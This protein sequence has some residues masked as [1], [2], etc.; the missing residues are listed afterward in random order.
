MP[1]KQHALDPKKY[2]FIDTSFNLLM[3]R[4]IYQILLISSNYDAFMLEEDGRIDETIFMEYFSLSLRYPPQ[5]IKVTSEEEAFEV[6]EDK[7]IELVISMLSIDQTDTF[8]LAIRIKN[9]FPKIPIVV[10]TPFSREVNIKL[11]EKNLSAID[12]VF[13]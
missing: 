12:Y 6:L 7:R 10:L 5:F 11:R 8:D 9:K 4:R 13:S 2:Y 3:K 1:N